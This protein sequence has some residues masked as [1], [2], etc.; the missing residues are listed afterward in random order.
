MAD[1]DEWF[2][3]EDGIL[4]VGRPTTG[5]TYH[6]S[7]HTLLVTTKDHA[8][9]VLDVTTGVILQN[10]DF[11]ESNSGNMQCTYLA[12]KDRVV[13]TDCKALGVR[14]DFNGVL[15]LETA[16][17]TPVGKTDDVVKV[18]LPLPEAGHLLHLLVTAELQGVEYV[19]DLLK[20][21]EKEID[22]TRESTKHNLKVAKWSTVCLK[23]PHAWL[24]TVC[25][26]LVAEMKRL[27]HYEPGL[28][29]ASAV[30]D[31]LGYLLVG[32][33][34]EV[35]NGPVDR[36]NMYS[37]AARRD[38]FGKWP[39][40]NYKWAL[41][42]PM[43]QAG[44]YHQPNSTG[45]DRAMCFTCNVCLVCWEPTDEPWSEH[46]RHSPSCPFVKGEY[47]QNV[48]L[49]VTYATGPAMLHGTLEDKITVV[50]RTSD[51]NY[52]ATSTQNGNIVV[53]SMERVLKKHVQFNIDPQDGVVR[54]VLKKSLGEESGSSS[55]ITEDSTGGSTSA[56]QATQD[57]SSASNMAQSTEGNAS[58]DECNTVEA[59]TQP[60]DSNKG[61][62]KIIEL[63]G[64]WQ[65]SQLVGEETVEI[66][67]GDNDRK[68][69]KEALA[70][71]RSRPSEDVIVSAL[72]VVAGGRDV[73]PSSL[74]QQPARPA[75]ISGV[76]FRTTPPPPPTV[77]TVN[78]S[79]GEEVAALNE[80]NQAISEDNICEIIPS[81][82]DSPKPELK[83]YLVVH[84]ILGSKPPSSK[85][86]A[87][88]MKIKPP[89]SGMVSGLQ[90]LYMH[91]QDMSDMEDNDMELSEISGIHPQTIT[92]TI[93]S[94]FGGGVTPSTTFGTGSSN[95]SKFGNVVE[96]K[97]T[98]PKQKEVTLSKTNFELHNSVCDDKNS[99]SKKKETSDKSTNTLP[100]GVTYKDGKIVQCLQLKKCFQPGFSISSVVPLPGGK[101][102]MVTNVPQ[103]VQDS[104]GDGDTRST[105]T[106]ITDWESKC[107]CAGIE[108][109][110]GCVWVYSMDYTGDVVTLK[111][112]PTRQFPIDSIGSSI[113]STLILPSDIASGVEDDDMG[114]K[115]VDPEGEDGLDVGG[116]I[117]VTTYDGRV[118]IR[119]LNSW[120]VLA[121]MKPTE[122]EDKFISLAFCSGVDRL[123]A[124]TKNGKLHFYMIGPQIPEFSE[125]DMLEH[126][127]PV[128]ERQRDSHTFATSTVTKSQS[129]P[130]VTSG[131]DLL[132]NQPLTAEVLHTLHNLTQFENLMPRFSAT[133][134][135]C[136]TEI[137]QEQQQRRHPQHLQ[138]Q[139][140]ATQHTRTW[141]L[142]PD[143]NTWD[144]HLFE[145]VL[146]KPCCVGHIDLKLTF[147]QLRSTPPALRVTLLKQNI[148]SLGRHP[149]SPTLPE[150]YPEMTPVDVDQ[151]INFEN[152]EEPKVTKLHSGFSAEFLEKHNAEVLCG[153]VDVGPCVDLSGHNAVIS[154]TSPMLLKVKSRSF[155]V[156][157]KV[158]E[159]TQKSSQEA[160]A[161]AEKE[162]PSESSAKK[163]KKE[164]T[165][166]SLFDNFEYPGFSAVE[167]LSPQPSKKVVESLRGCNWI[168]E[169]SIT[170]RKAKKSTV[171]KDRIQRCAMLDTTSFY[172]QL[173]L[174]V[175]DSDTR[176]SHQS[177][178]AY[179]QNTAL[180]ILCWITA[181]QMNHPA[182]SGD[183]HSS[184]I[185]TIQSNLN[186][187]IKACFIDNGRT[188]AHRCAR[189]LAL[190]ME[191]TKGSD[192]P[193]MAPAF[194]FSLLVALL[195]CLPM[196]PRAKSAGSLHWYFM[197][198]NRVKCMDAGVTG[199]RCA[200]LL[201]QVASSYHERL[202]PLHSILKAR[203]GLYGSPLDIEMFDTEPPPVLKTSN[204][205]NS[206]S[207][208]ASIV[209]NNNNNLG[210]LVN[211]NFP[212][213]SAGTTSSNNNNNV[214][215]PQGFDEVDF[216]DLLSLSG[217][218]G[219]KQGEKG[220]IQCYGLLEVEP[221]HF[222]C[223]A[224]SDGTRMERLDS[225]G[226]VSNV[227]GTSGLSGTIN[228]AEGLPNVSQAGAALMSLST[229]MASAEQQLSQLQQKQQQLIKLQYQKQKLEQKLAETKAGGPSTSQPYSY[230][231]DLMPPTPK[232]TPFFMTPPVTPPNEAWTSGLGT[233]STETDIGKPPSGPS[234]SQ[235]SGKA[236][237]KS[238]VSKSESGQLC[239]VPL[240][241]TQQLLQPPPAQVLVIERM[242]SG[243]RRFVVLDFGKPILL[244]DIIIPACADLA[245]LSI[246]V[247]TH[248]E[249]SDGQRL[250]VST[251]IGLRSLIMND[252]ISPPICRYLKITIIGRYGGNATRSRI[253]IGSFYGN[254]FILPWESEKPQTGETTDG[255]SNQ[256][257]L[258]Q[259]QILGHL[260]TMINLQEDIQCRYSLAR[261]R[262]ESLLLGLDSTQNVN[263]HTTYYLSKG[264]RNEEDTKIFHAYNDCLQLQLQWNLA[265]HAMERLQ[266][267]IGLNTPNHILANT[268]ILIKQ[269][270]VDHLRVISELLLNT[271]LS[272]T[273]STPT[274]P[275][276]PV[277]LYTVFDL[278]FC[279]ALFNK[280]C[281]CGS[282]QTQ[283][284]TGMLL[285]RLC[286]NQPWWGDFLGRALQQLYSTEQHLTFPQDRV[287]MLLS[288]L[289][290]KALTGNKGSDMID[291][292]LALLT[293][294]LSPLTGE[295]QAYAN[296]H[297]SLD[298][299]LVG[300]LVLLLSRCLDSTQLATGASEDNGA[301]GGKDKESTSTGTT[302]SI[303]NR[304]DFVQGET[305]ISNQQTVSKSNNLR[306]Y[307]RRLQKRL[308][309][310]K[311]Q[312]LDIQQAKKHFM[313]SQIE[314]SAIGLNKEAEAALKQQE[315]IFKK[316]LKQYS[317]KHYKDFMQIR[318][319]E[320]EV[321][322]KL[323]KN[324]K[325]GTNGT[326]GEADGD[327]ET[328]V[329]LPRDRCIPV[330]KGLINLLL[331]MDFTCNVDLFL[332]SCK[333]VAKVCMSCR[334]AVT[335]AEMMSQ[336]ELE[337]LLLR[338]TD[339]EHNHGNISWGGPWAGHAVSCLLQD[340]LEGEKIFPIVEETEIESEGVSEEEIAA[341][342][343]P[344]DATT[345]PEASE[346]VEVTDDSIAHSISLPNI[347]ESHLT[348]ASGGDTSKDDSFKFD[349]ESSLIVDMLL[350]DEQYDDITNMHLQDYI[351]GNAGVSV[352]QTN[353]ENVNVQVIQV[354]P[355]PGSETTDNTTTTYKSWTPWGPPNS[356]KLIS[357]YTNHLSPKL[358]QSLKKYYSIANLSKQQEPPPLKTF[359]M[360]DKNPKMDKWRSKLTD[361]IVH[362]SSPPQGVSTAMDARLETGLDM[363]AELRLRVM[364]S[365]DVENVQSAITSPLPA[366][367][368]GGAQKNPR[369]QQ[370]VTDDELGGIN[371][372]VRPP[373]S[374]TEMLSQCF[375]QLFTQLQLQRVNLDTILELWLTLNDETSLDDNN[376][377]TFDPTRVPS[378]GLDEQ[379][380]T[381][382]LAALAW[383]PSVAVRT[384]A[385]AF[386]TLTLLA[387][388]KVSDRVGRDKWLATVMVADSNMRAVI[389]KFLSGSNPGGSSVA[390][391]SC[392]QVGPS[393][394]QAFHEFLVR[395]QLCVAEPS[396]SHL[397]ESVLK[398]VFTLTT[399][400]GA[401]HSGTG[402][403]DAQCKLLEH[404]LEQNFDNV[405][406]NNAISVIEAISA[407]VHQHIISQEKVTCK[408]TS[409]GSVSA[410]SCFGGLFSSMLRP[411]RSK[412]M[413]GD[414]FRDV[415]M[416]DLL[417][418]VNILLQVELPGRGSN[419]T[420]QQRAE[421]SVSS[422]SA[423]DSTASVSQSDEE[424]QN[425]GSS[426]TDTGQT[427]EEKS[428]NPTPVVQPIR[429][430]SCTHFKDM[431]NPAL[432]GKKACLADVILGHNH[433]MANLLQAL[434]CCHS[435]TMAM[436]LGSSGLQGNIQENFTGIDPVSVGDGIFQILCTL[437][438]R[439]TSLEL[440]LKPIHSYLSAGFQGGHRATGVCRLS[441]PLL[442][443]FLRVLDCQY[444]LKIFLDMGGVAIVCRNLVESNR[445][446]VSTNPSM[447][448]TLMQ[449]LSSHNRQSGSSSKKPTS[450]PADSNGDGL[451]NFAPLGTISSSSPSAGPA[452]VLI[453]QLPPHRRNRSAAW[454][455]HFYPD[456]AWVDLT[457]VLPCAILL[458]EVHIMPHVISLS[459]CPSS[460]AI[461]ISR[462]GS[463]MMPICPPVVTNGL[464]SIKLQLHKPEV[465][466]M[467]TIRLHK[468]RDSTTIGLSQ[469]M[470]LGHT[471]FGQDSSPRGTTIFT[472]SEDYVSKTSIGWLR[473]LHHCLTTAE[474]LQP[475]IASTAPGSRDLLNTCTALLVAP[476]SSMYASNIESVLLKIG[477]HSTEL[478]IAVIDNLLRNMAQQDDQ[479]ESGGQPCLYGKVNGIAND[480]T[481]EILYQLGI[482]QNDGSQ[483]RVQ[484][485]LQWLGDSARIALQKSAIYPDDGWRES[486][487][488]TSSFEILPSPAAAHVHCI[489]AL[490]WHSQELG[491][492]YDLH[493]VVTRDLLS[494][495]YEWSTVLESGSSLKKA[496]D[497]VICSMCYIHPQYFSTLL[498]WMGIINSGNVIDVNITDDC[499]HP[500]QP[501][502]IS[503]TDDSKEANAAARNSQPIIL[504]EFS[505]MILDESH[506]GI[507]ATACQSP[508]AIKQLLYS[509]FPGVLA[510]G[511]MDF[512][513]R[514]VA[515]CVDMMSP[516]SEEDVFKGGASSQTTPRSAS[517]SS[518]SESYGLEKGVSITADLVS[519]VLQFLAEIGKE[520]LVKDW[521][522][523]NDGNIFW[524]ILLTMLCTSPPKTS[525]LNPA[526]PHR[527][528]VLSSQQRSSIET[529]AI[530]FF[531]SVISCHTANQMLFAQ[532]L[533]DVIRAQKIAP[534]NGQWGQAHLS[535]F[536]RRLFLQVL[537]EDEKIL[538]CVRTSSRA[539]SRRGSGGPA[540]SLIQH[541]KFGTGHRYKNHYIS[542]QSTC[543]ETLAKLSDAPSLPNPLVE[544]SKEKKSPSEETASSN[545]LGIEIVE[546]LSAAAGIHA[547]E[548][549]D[550]TKDA[551]NLPPR[552]PTRRGR[553]SVLDGSRLTDALQIPVLSLCHKLLPGQHLPSDLTLAQLLTLLHN[554]GHPQGSMCLDFALKLKSKRGKSSLDPETPSSS[555]SSELSD[556]DQEPIPDSVLLDTTPFA[557]PLQVFA[558]LGG[559]ALLAEHLPLLYPEITRQ[560]S[561]PN[562][563]K[564]V[565]GSTV[566]GSDWVTVESSDDIY[567]EIY[568]PIPTSTH[569]KTTRHATP[570]LPTIPPHSLVAFGLFLRLPGYAD[571]LLKE[572]KK[573]Q[574]LLRLVLGVT[575]DGDGGH[576][577]S[578]PIATSL[579]TLPFHVLKTLFDTSPLTT[580]DGV[581]LRRMALDIGALHLILACLSVLS[582]QGP[583]TPIPGFHQEIILA[584]TQ[585][586]MTVSNNN[587]APT[588]KPELEKG[589]H[590]WAKGTGF[591]TGSTSSSWDAEQALLRQRSEEEH[592]T[593]LLQVFAS[594]VWPQTDETKSAEVGREPVGHSEN[595]GIPDNLPELLSQSCLV[596]AISSYLRNDS[597]LDMA[598]HVPLYR[599]LLE[600]LRAISS[601]TVLVPLLLPLDDVASDNSTSIASLLMKM[602]G[603]VDTY[604]SRL[605]GGNSK[606]GKDGK[607][608]DDENEG[609]ALLIPDIQQ[610][611]NIVYASSEKC[612]KKSE[613]DMDDSDESD[614]KGASSADVSLDQRYLTTIKELQFDTCEMVT[615][616]DSGA[617]KFVT[618]HHY[619]P[620][621]KA[622]GTVNNAARSRRLAQEAVTLS[623]S[624]PLSY[625]SS[626]FVR[627][628]EERLD[629]MKVLITGPVDTP[630]A[631]GC[632]EF[633][634]FFP[635][636][637]PNSPPL[638]NLETTGNHSIRFNP[639]LYNDGKVC[640]SVLNTW[641]GRP[642]EKWNSQTSS[643]LQVLVS[644]QSLILV[645]EPYF[646]EPGYER[647]RGTPTGNASSREYDANIRQA[648]VKWAMLEQIKN[649]KSCFKEVIHRHFWYKREEVCQQIDEWIEDLEANTSDKR[650]GRA[651]AHSLVALR[652]HY[653][654]LKE[655]FAKM[656]I[657]SD[658]EDEV[659]DS[660][661]DDVIDH[662]TKDKPVAKETAPSDSKKSVSELTVTLSSAPMIPI[663]VEETSN[664]SVSNGPVEQKEEATDSPIPLTVSTHTTDIKPLQNGPVEP[665]DFTD[666]NKVTNPSINVKKLSEVKVLT[667]K[668]D[669]SDPP[670]VPDTT[671]PNTQSVST[672]TEEA[673]SS[674][675]PV[676]NH[677]GEEEQIEE[678][679]DEIDGPLDYDDNGIYYY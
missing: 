340:V 634:V 650:T 436:I 540:S 372:V 196:I 157:L 597:V 558:S 121:E 161:S 115:G 141:R 631:N 604:A 536:T 550:K 454:S 239:N 245:S 368:S 431:K 359:Y 413:F 466:S 494:C 674:L 408:S 9:Q 505:H 580:D 53:W 412:S 235:G 37:E 441:E 18:E 13:F 39:H 227:S 565:G 367:P 432:T 324:G 435:N 292:L 160:A 667:M 253:P 38:T 390:Q 514:E 323:P 116:Q 456:E 434:A 457:I 266:E 155:L 218:K 495:L 135:P 553:H 407:L 635:Q 678:A 7:L 166:K 538:V 369:Q 417:K 366:V 643:F 284:T 415:L 63:T 610:T 645:S 556:S 500:R 583:R 233:Y 530:A 326:T 623:T 513:A 255:V 404:I 302:T 231:T 491:V 477:L 582:H 65:T 250:V 547:K 430:R 561:P 496:V 132:V 521:L 163:K 36:L 277:T 363:R 589:Q 526:H 195:E 173:L 533:C 525:N 510:Q 210:S 518:S 105:D 615:D 301:S 470:L 581:L 49:S 655:E 75:L 358:Q 314:K 541:P 606:K 288:A 375:S 290:Q 3:G 69:I 332:V 406:I 418:L 84:D 270:S 427:D 347:E 622:A 243:A 46:E 499:K 201:A 464:T 131:D 185:Y 588:N 416:C 608:E 171:A 469:L 545:E 576:I 438:C 676:A 67:L 625:S 637:Y 602:K 315:A 535:G 142:Q 654:Q 159:T 165:F 420:D 264:K 357:N 310:H 1:P 677:V 497:N 183:Q 443:L 5:L 446:I 517:R 516:S 519:A 199:Q 345:P 396:K 124:A 423:P 399:D 86:K 475:Y 402:P 329:V 633:D 50:G 278:G 286:G 24:K 504:Q 483:A 254:T 48:P 578:S 58:H 658:I 208:Y 465:A 394:V 632:F 660:S 145:V 143:G 136:W 551:P 229:A 641:H 169:L 351:T 586:A 539:T 480:S 190:C 316:Q 295:Y 238:S 592:V 224:T 232:N 425:G 10:A 452:E 461:E 619:Q 531:S 567:E 217:D 572:R 192:D 557:S 398:L 468:P 569:A 110:G 321:L 584:A 215:G 21:L 620:N 387:N 388:V 98:I 672:S 490:L 285:V 223:H 47:T 646:N 6:S 596:P 51:D 240:P 241:N 370:S 244:T 94:K 484:A 549:R 172:E 653:S 638:I 139:G 522:G 392:T 532:V 616:D 294:L 216:R 41:P 644:I 472:P 585:A 179:R 68:A 189:L 293:K 459:T 381:S 87:S 506:F 122:E 308:M 389:V 391:N 601:C 419:L 453:Q 613:S 383:S 664:V 657:P 279:E 168:Q 636:D 34:D 14:R 97:V 642:E 591:G 385:L 11:S 349:Q 44:F 28:S 428:E 552:P 603:C 17:Q 137:Q 325:T 333:V 101:H 133:V 598:R 154:L 123:C 299:Q 675:T 397:K 268:G 209:Q 338:C 120:S 12:E 103:C 303:S 219:K 150:V 562:S 204:S 376:Q 106:E 393:T 313:S 373:V 22:A 15:L 57:L 73:P 45:D 320:C 43:A 476:N 568:E 563:S 162:K 607:E 334:P 384:W 364:Q 649:T 666:S 225:T 374:S 55:N 207:T 77:D 319:F 8:I 527:H 30:S 265:K 61:V 274:I 214:G 528:K 440:M 360:D 130:K 177:S 79:T 74:T 424:K 59:A 20:E 455:Y 234:S 187:L 32:G 493:Q 259:S 458:K 144:E 170:I 111:P 296:S 221:L 555:D 564:E 184:V 605:K 107:S 91:M 595:S 156:H 25:S 146:P 335:L 600:L 599:A 449:Y 305:A 251:D 104:M 426:S 80:V 35:N 386:R 19:E 205:S 287:F 570:T 236:T 401:F 275:Q 114:G 652:R 339:L 630:Y 260:A 361:L 322:K 442:W 501:E 382:L 524:P 256:N 543:A 575:D 237:P 82:S 176:V 328:L 202:N 151:K 56:E 89:S 148:S 92:P 276:P 27:H 257:F 31:R 665:N 523:S 400:R 331:S 624:L 350:E 559:L 618:P 262:L 663:S 627:C 651:V 492:V 346:T 33:K 574:C 352:S 341:M 544:A 640:L 356:S 429:I 194:N 213:T 282:R 188:V 95:V 76:Q 88:E 395:L 54:E 247:W 670:P 309:H 342:S 520:S 307:R 594:Y 507:L 125:I 537:L 312:L 617:L 66:P 147:H 96:T 546:N 261:N 220:T 252:L 222:T 83:P 593:C 462:D 661:N 283:V 317:S 175:C 343:E 52:I 534:S 112:E 414:S 29:V 336:S 626:V 158:L 200:E 102:V 248:S 306:Q 117:A 479:S 289:A 42:D 487:R 281:V 149:N 16:L 379:A 197:L 203:Y 129:V 71:E 246:D 498:E 474:D 318:R 405:D 81:R 174:T 138:Q 353:N 272:M 444:S 127:S 113:T 560:V 181:L 226:I 365:L 230:S 669:K 611:A 300:W 448:S 460:V 433:T 298:L 70:C 577:L 273:S 193:D 447:I 90:D 344:D 437:N 656:K 100:V 512:C 93:V 134:P 4:S 508:L 579:P 587:G 409:E 509:G 40:M 85:V 421:S 178:L 206:P 212:T 612:R 486:P 152:L 473:M 673:E 671:L 337:K 410:R 60:V 571:V 489:A 64:A 668:T 180:D 439:A 502:S 304:W 662:M 2:V 679:I 228:F 515:R 263:S 621:V 628:D 629:I 639:N 445:H 153:P 463:I 99:K 26:A 267:T 511:L 354:Q 371:I 109:Q 648:T 164:K 422:E 128:R 378:I 198:L 380:V 377:V 330:V 471:A 126:S 258:D 23:L 478:G 186:G 542:L 488:E 211:D 355:A 182:D 481:I 467:V 485:M 566:P 62:A 327:L 411:V 118:Q 554:K 614:A 590:Y 119:S 191:F 271:I 362:K 167:R 291:S 249:E 311:Q 269:A 280:L 503:Q 78:T 482:K 647:S 140:E 108:D 450:A 72:C 529:S 573:A 548:K 403:I 242:H 609:L 451:Q 659:D 297:G 348:Q